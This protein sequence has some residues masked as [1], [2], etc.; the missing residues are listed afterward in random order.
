M[1]GSIS[2]TCFPLI[3]IR[4]YELAV[5]H[6]LT[7]AVARQ[8]TEFRD[9]AVSPKGARGLMQI[10]PS[11]GSEVASRIGLR[12]NIKRLLADREYNL[13]IGS[14]YL[15][16]LLEKFDGSYLLAIAAYNAGP[17]RVS[18]WLREQGRSP[19]GLR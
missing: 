19:S 2:I 14:G 6:A 16:Y 7:I 17:A 9:L 3:G 4:D 18:G 11:T 5:P 13:R 1:A 15:D 8:E 10:K 12:G